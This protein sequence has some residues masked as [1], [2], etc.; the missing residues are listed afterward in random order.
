[1][2]YNNYQKS[3]CGKCGI[4]ADENHIQEE[5][6]SC[7]TCG[8]VM[9]LTN[10][11]GH[12]HSVWFAQ[13]WAVLSVEEKY[14]I[15]LTILRLFN[16]YGGDKGVIS[17]FKK[18]NIVKVYG[19]TVRDFIHVSVVAS[20]IKKELNALCGI[21]IKDVGTGIPTKIIDLAI[22]T[23]KPIERYIQKEND[24]II[25]YKGRFPTKWTG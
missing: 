12:W 14:A 5:H 2:N 24:I 7:N 6:V 1:L 19:D 3:I 21:Q 17:E 23:G 20:I 8:R 18:A 11:H 16:V 22:K 9:T 4:Y 10:A 13:A 25:S 15:D